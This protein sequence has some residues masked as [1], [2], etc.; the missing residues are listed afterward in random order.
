MAL[1]YY[2]I[3]IS[4]FTSNPSTQLLENFAFLILFFSGSRVYPY[5]ERRSDFSRLVFS[6]SDHLRL[7]CSNFD[8]E[9]LVSMKLTSSQSES[10]NTVF[11][12]PNRSNTEYFNTHHSNFIERRKPLTRSNRIPISLQCSKTIVSK[13]VPFTFI[14]LISQWR[15]RHFS[16]AIC[17]RFAP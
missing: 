6:N 7:Q 13:V 11:F 3:T 1:F 15:N 17:D 10:T 2:S 9:R 12:N 16:K 4:Y 14:R 8:S 5:D